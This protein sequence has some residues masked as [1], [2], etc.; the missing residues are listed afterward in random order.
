MSTQDQ[1]QAFDD[2]GAAIGSDRSFGLIVG[3]IIVVIASWPLLRG[4]SPYYIALGI[5]GALMLFALVLPRVLHPLN[6]AWMKFGLLLG[7]I[8]TPIIMFAVYAMTVVPIGLLLRLFGKDVLG[9]Q[10]KPEGQSYW[11]ERDPP[12]PEPESLK[13]QF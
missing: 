1:T 12:G 3:G 7:T 4:E 2:H 6:R 9:L 11:I 10:R 13:Q 5:G 8:V